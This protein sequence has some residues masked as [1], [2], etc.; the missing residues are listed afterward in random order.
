MQRRTHKT[1][2]EAAVFVSSID[3]LGPNRLT[4]VQQYVFK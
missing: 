2:P 1:T 3:V 4:F